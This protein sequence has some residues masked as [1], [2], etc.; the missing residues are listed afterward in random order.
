MSFDCNEIWVPILCTPQLLF[1][2]NSLHVSGSCD[3]PAVFELLFPSASALAILFKGD[4]V[5]GKKGSG[6]APCPPLL[7]LHTAFP[8]CLSCTKSKF[9]N[10]HE[11]SLLLLELIVEFITRWHSPICHQHF[12]HFLPSDT[13]LQWDAFSM[14]ELQNF[15]RIL[16]RE[17]EEHIRQILQKYAHCRQKMQEALAT[18]T[19]G[20]QVPNPNPDNRCKEAMKPSGLRVMQSWDCLWTECVLERVGKGKQGCMTLCMS[21][22]LVHVCLLPM[23][24]V[25]HRDF[26]CMSQWDQVGR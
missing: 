5:V 7:Y 26:A 1:F 25:V 11:C 20:W 17:E 10:Y 16:Q 24:W 2:R 12:V 13:F 23:E 18:R 9:P 3:P 22:R 15:L 21:S 14:P 6:G 19:P 8:T 4:G